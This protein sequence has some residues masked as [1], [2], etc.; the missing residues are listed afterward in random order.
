MKERKIVKIFT[1]PLQ[2]PC[3]PGSSC[4]G[5][6]GQSE[7][8]LKKLVETI[9][10]LGLS[11]EVHDIME[12]NK[13]DESFPDIS[14]LIGSFG[15]A[16]IPIIAIDDEVISMGPPSLEEAKQTIKEKLST[17]EV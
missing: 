16:V 17:M 8:D 3:G 12:E 6:I 15:P 2:F 1:A 4:C 11:V 9:K 10:E 13:F 7:E 5:P 14:N